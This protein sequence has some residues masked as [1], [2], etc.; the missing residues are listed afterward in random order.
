[1]LGRNAA[2]LEEAVSAG[3]AH[4]AAVADV[5]DEGALKAAQ[6][7]IEFAHVMAPIAGRVSRRL[8]TPG[9]LVQ[10]SDGASTLLTSIVPTIVS[11]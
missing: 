11:Y 2:I 5:S 6:L 8:V 3:A 4:F 9:N 10:G 7:N 1:M